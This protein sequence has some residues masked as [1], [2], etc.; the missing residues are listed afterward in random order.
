[1]NMDRNKLLVF[2][3]CLFGFS[4]P[5]T[6]SAAETLLFLTLMM[7][8]IAWLQRRIR[9]PMDS[10]YLVPVLLFVGIATATAFFGERPGQSMHRL[11]RL[12]FP[13]ILLMMGIR[14]NDGARLPR[15]WLRYSV[16]SFLIGVAVL[17]VT[18]LVR[19]P[20]AVNHGVSWFNAGNMRDPQMYLVSLCILAPLWIAPDCRAWRPFLSMGTVLSL[21][22]ILLHFKRGVWASLLIAMLLLSVLT[23]RWIILLVMVGLVIGAALVPQ[24]QDRV[25]DLKL[26]TEVGV[27]GRYALWTEVA[28][29]L[30]PEYPMG[31]GWGA[32]RHSDLAEHADYVQPK[33]NHLHNN[34]LQIAVEVGWL[35]LLAWLLWMSTAL[36]LCMRLLQKS[37]GKIDMD[38]AILMGVL[39]GLVGLL[40][41]GMVEY[42]FG[43]S[44]ILLLYCLLM[45]WSE[46]MRDSSELEVGAS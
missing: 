17:G 46:W 28:P 36:L 29:N 1:M 13:F 34:V 32:M 6:I 23:R 21:L 40:A 20:Y 27:G 5:L 31:L 18:D 24:V 2:C 42:N 22:G 35:G 15:Q 41:N 10:P 3:F 26:V 12:L 25:R 37:A 33:L 44:E 8:F 19:I 43:D 16:V 7:G 39:C 38:S 30:I 4:V 11:H 9:V 45:G 14:G